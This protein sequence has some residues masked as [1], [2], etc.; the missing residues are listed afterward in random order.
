MLRR[1]LG[2]AEFLG[3]DGAEVYRVLPLGGEQEEEEEDGG[4]GHFDG[5]EGSRGMPKESRSWQVT[6]PGLL[7]GK[8]VEEGVGL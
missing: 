2:A 3:E 5:G 8:V 1:L 7:S 4:G 6:D